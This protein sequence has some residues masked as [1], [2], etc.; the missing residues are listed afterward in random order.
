MATV[1]A[2]IESGAAPVCT[3]VDDSLNMDPAD[4]LRRITSRTKAVIVIHMLRTPARLDQ[5]GG[6]MR[7]A[8]D[9]TH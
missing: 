7:K 9:P 2:I 3:E 4:L 6:H 5:I 1:E 8:E